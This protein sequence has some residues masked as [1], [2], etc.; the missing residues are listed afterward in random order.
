MRFDRGDA[1]LKC[2]GVHIRMAAGVHMADKPGLGPSLQLAQKT[3]DGNG[4][5]GLCLMNIRKLRLGR[6]LLA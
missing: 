1:A 2:A 3:I 5:N 6:A 4:S